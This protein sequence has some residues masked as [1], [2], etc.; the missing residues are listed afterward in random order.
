MGAVL[1]GG[2]K[3]SRKKGV[4]VQSLGNTTRW[5]KRQS[6]PGEK[7]SRGED[8]LDE[9]ANGAVRVQQVLHQA[10]LRGAEPG[11]AAVQEMSRRLSGG[12]MHILPFRVPAGKQEQNEHHLQAVR[13]KCCL[14]WKT[15][16]LPVLPAAGCLCGR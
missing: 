6:K 9:G 10:P 14:I 16:Q 1:V 11:P 7:A 8:E 12:E 13:T 4:G 15:N 2:F 5:E 3:P